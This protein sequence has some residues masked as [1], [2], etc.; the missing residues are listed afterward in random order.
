ME[1]EYSK[2]NMEWLSYYINKNH[3]LT[4]RKKI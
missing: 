1:L 2:T 4:L 3:A